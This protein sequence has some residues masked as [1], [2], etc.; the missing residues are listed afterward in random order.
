MGDYE[1]VKYDSYHRNISDSGASNAFDPFA[2]PTSSNYNW[3][4]TNTDDN[5]LVGV[6]LDW[7]VTEKFTI[8]GSLLYFQS[9]GQSDV[10]S[11]NNFGNPLPIAAYDNWKRTSLNLKG[12]YAFSKNW[13]FTGGYAYE[14]TRYSDIA[15]DGYQ[16]TIPYP[17]VT[18]NT[19]Q[20][21]LNG[22]RA[23]T[24]ANA[25]IFYLLATYKF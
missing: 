25:N 11:Q 23:F 10:F 7:F 17:A 4:A 6:G 3:S 8:K 24:N 9:D 18:T 2:T 20:S 14:K 5:W 21:Y 1:W 16:Y 19:G 15:F 22:Y 12:I 13:S